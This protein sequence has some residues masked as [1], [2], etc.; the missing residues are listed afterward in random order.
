[1]FLNGVI[2]HVSVKY[3]VSAGCT[4]I[5]DV[6]LLVA[7]WVVV[8]GGRGGVCVLKVHMQFTLVSLVP[9]QAVSLWLS[10]Q[11]SNMNIQKL[12]DIFH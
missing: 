5:G 10:V 2:V 11:V 4:H 3:G 12:F 7:E 9:S 6:C 8:V 1:M